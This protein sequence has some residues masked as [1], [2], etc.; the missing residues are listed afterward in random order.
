MFNVIRK[1]KMNVCINCFTYIED[2]INSYDLKT[3]EISTWILKA[4]LV[5]QRLLKDEDTLKQPA[6]SG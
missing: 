2:L 6:R 5:S 4:G 1:S 3:N